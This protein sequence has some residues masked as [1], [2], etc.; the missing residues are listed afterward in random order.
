MQAF[1]GNRIVYRR[2]FICLANKRFSAKFNSAP[3]YER[4]EAEYWSERKE[5][6]KNAK[7]WENYWLFSCKRDHLL[8]FRAT[9]ADQILRNVQFGFKRPQKLH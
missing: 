8:T 7:I 5:L 6:V 3:N 1:Q 4:P 2:L 9:K